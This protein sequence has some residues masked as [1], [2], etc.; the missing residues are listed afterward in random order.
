[1]ALM[2]YVTRIQFGLGALQVLKDELIGAGIRRPMIVTDAGV[3]AAGLLERLLG[4]LDPGMPVF[5]ATPENPT[6]AAARDTLAM[7]RAEACDGLV[8][9]G[10]GSPID[11]AKA[12]AV[13]VVGDG[14]LED[15]AFDR[16]GLN[17]FPKPLPPLVAVPTTAGTGSEVGGGSL[18]TFASGRKS[19]IAGQA[20][21]PRVAICDPELTLGLPP[22]LT[23]ATG[24]DALSHCI[25]TYLSPRDNPIADAIAVEGLVRGFH[26]LPRAVANGQDRGARTDM[27]LAATMGALAFQKGLGAVHALSHPLGAKGH[28][29]GTLNAIFLPHVLERNAR[30]AANKMA[31]L[32]LRLGLTL[33]LADALRAL[34]SKVDLPA[35]L[36]ELGVRDGELRDLAPL[37]LREAAHDTNPVRLT[38]D[39]YAALYRAAF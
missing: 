29:H 19:L 3:T 4:Q 9:L 13:L 6:E 35:K 15:L 14:S 30:S 11:L 1:M 37:C 10:G 39:D 8:A 24:M 25:E 21:V 22:R 2:N 18:V 31:A 16:V 32:E 33:G 34:S 17:S 5:D 7:F 36:S 38:E 28:H 26:A 23:A 20:L 12:V 27:M